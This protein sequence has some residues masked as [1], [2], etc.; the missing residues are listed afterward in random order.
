MP[1]KKSNARSVPR[2]RKIRNKPKAII[3]PPCKAQ[4]DKMSPG[5]LKA[6]AEWK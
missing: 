5:V 1:R 4:D 6:V 2:P 3:L